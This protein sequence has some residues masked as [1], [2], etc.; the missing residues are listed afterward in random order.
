[1]S[2]PLLVLVLILTLLALCQATEVDQ[3]TQRDLYADSLPD[4]L[5]RL[6]LKTNSLLNQ[7][8]EA[9]NQRFGP[10]ASGKPVLSK[11][12]TWH[13]LALYI[14]N[15][16]ARENQSGLPREE[17]PIPETIDLFRA[18]SK[19]GRGPLQTWC[20]DKK[21]QGSYLV[22]FDSHIYRDAY[23]VDFNGVFILKVAG[24]L[25]GTDKLDHFF[26]QGYEY[27]YLSKDGTNTARAL[28]YGVNSERGLFGITL[29]GVFSFGD[30]RGN[31]QGYQFYKNL[32]SY[33][34]VR[35][36]GRMAQIRSFDWADWIDWQF[37]EILNPSYYTP[38]LFQRL[39]IW[40][41]D[42]EKRFQLGQTDYS[43]HHSWLT[44]SAEGLL[45]H[46]KWQRSNEYFNSD[47][48][49]NFPCLFDA[50]LSPTR[51]AGR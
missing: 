13:Y 41:S 32:A 15:Y 30:L 14:H 20:E 3:F 27:W 36:D 7:A 24:I 40:M 21:V 42:Q 28:A 23:P 37:D 2:K 34:V 22:N 25:S 51:I 9:W 10:D 26:D 31:W 35:P 17:E 43:Y 29:S 48:P 18:L 33:F 39:R 47:A 49:H 4:S 44:L 5:E 6:N 19:A 12:Q 11:L 45:D 50:D 38:E 16:L 46:G 1:M 8:L